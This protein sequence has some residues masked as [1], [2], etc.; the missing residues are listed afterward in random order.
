[1]AGWESFV[2]FNWRHDKGGERVDD[3]ESRL[4]IF[5]NFKGLNWKLIWGL[6]KG[7]E[8]PFFLAMLAK[9][10]PGGCNGQECLFGDRE[11]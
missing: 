9:C 3:L 4:A 5:L 2:A 8:L 10:A 6:D 11:I 1:M 7:E